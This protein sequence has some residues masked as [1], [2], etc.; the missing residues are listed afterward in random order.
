MNASEVAVWVERLRARQGLPA[1]VTDPA[2]IRTVVV[3][4]GGGEKAGPAPA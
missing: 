4:L 3:L 1:K 2:V